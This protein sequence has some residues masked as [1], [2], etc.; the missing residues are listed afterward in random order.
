MI[1][2]EEMDAFCASQRE[3]DGFCRCSTACSGPSPS[4]LACDRPFPE[5]AEVYRGG[6]HGS[7]RFE[8]ER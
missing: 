6:N 8:V 5:G 1:T 4:N 3:A 7:C 2:Y